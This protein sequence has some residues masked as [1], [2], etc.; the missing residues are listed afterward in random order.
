MDILEPSGCQMHCRLCLRS[1]KTFGECVE[2][3]EN[4]NKAILEI[5][6]LDV[7]LQL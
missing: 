5:F 4:V 6:P 7:S 1:L 2:I 3:T